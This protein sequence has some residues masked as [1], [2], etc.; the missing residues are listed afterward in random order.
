MSAKIVPSLYQVFLNFVLDI[1]W[2][3]VSLDKKGADGIEYLIKLDYFAKKNFSKKCPEM[4]L[5]H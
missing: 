1:K 3:V 5:N 4:D 2:F